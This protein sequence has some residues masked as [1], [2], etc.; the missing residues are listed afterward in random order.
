MKKKVLTTIAIIASAV[1]LVVG[2]IAG[3]VAY[4]RA[5]A[6]VVN[7]FTYGKVSITMDET[8]IGE[9]GLTPAASTQRVTGNRYKLMPGTTYVKD[10]V[11]HVGTESEDMYLFLKVDNG[12]AGLAVTDDTTGTVTIRNQLLNNGWKVYTNDSSV[13]YDV[14]TETTTN[15]GVIIKAT[16]TIY[17]LSVADAADAEKGETAETPKIINGAS[18]DIKTFEK[19]TTGTSPVTEASMTAYVNNNAKIGVTAFAVQTSGFNN[20]HEAAA[21]FASEFASAIPTTSNP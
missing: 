1:L 7:T 12:I 8:L 15:S 20:I 16:S 19:F 5:T 14:A 2:S 21:V 18:G 17:Y 6:E 10:P 3:T 9:D 13:A 11:I 4:L